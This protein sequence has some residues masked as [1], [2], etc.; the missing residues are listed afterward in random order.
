LIKKYAKYNLFTRNCKHFASD[1][2]RL[3]IDHTLVEP[4]FGVRYRF[5]RHHLR[6]MNTVQYS[7][8]QLGWIVP[9]AE[10]I[11]VKVTQTKHDQEI[12][13]GEVEGSGEQGMFLCTHHHPLCF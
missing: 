9:S 4:D 8:P 1:L 12:W 11:L 10:K 7:G 6:V 3:I 5:T 2:A 13:E